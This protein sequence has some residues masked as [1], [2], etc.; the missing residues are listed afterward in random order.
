VSV[1][2]S[3]PDDLLT[4]EAYLELE[5]RSEVRH[6]RV[7]GRVVAMSGGTER[8]D[9]AALSSRARL[10]DDVE[11][12]GCVVFAHNRLLR[13]D[14][15][16]RYPDVLSRCGRPA[17]DQ[18]ENDARILV[19]VLSPDSSMRDRRD[20]ASMYVRL[21]GLEAYVVV[22]PDRPTVEVLAPEDGV[23]VWRAFGPGSTIELAGWV[24]DVDQLHTYLD[25]V[26][27]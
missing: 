12:Q 15:A 5:A 2:A 16:F 13:I 8:H 25:A 21:R 1:H 20:K 7:G 6:E 3:Y 19:E 18:Y 14:N 23:W 22:D 27:G 9:L 26:A 24:W 4:V 17:S 11:P 10:A